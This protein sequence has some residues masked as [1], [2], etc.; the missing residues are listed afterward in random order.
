MVQRRETTSP[1]LITL[2][3]SPSTFF[4]WFTPK[5]TKKIFFNSNNINNLIIKN[6]NVIF[7]PWQNSGAGGIFYIGHWHKSDGLVKSQRPQLRE[8]TDAQ[9]TVYWKERGMVWC[10]LNLTVFCIQWTFYESINVLKAYRDWKLT[11][12][13]KWLAKIWPSVKAAIEY[14]WL[15]VTS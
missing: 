12:D 1:V 14:S 3:K 13:L 5:I 6:N 7:F 11:G 2:S 15:V 4:R 8:K 9:N 10:P